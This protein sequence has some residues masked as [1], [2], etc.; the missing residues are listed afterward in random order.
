MCNQP[1]HTNENGDAKQT[2]CDQMHRLQYTSAHILVN[3][4]INDIF[5]KYYSYNNPNI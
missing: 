4:N 3:K 5:V 2:E 1:L